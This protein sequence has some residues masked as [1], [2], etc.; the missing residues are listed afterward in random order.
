MQAFA[1]LTLGELIS[2]EFLNNQEQFERGLACL[3]K[4]VT[5]YSKNAQVFT[6]GEYSRVNL[7]L[8]TFYRLKGDFSQAKRHLELAKDKITDKTDRSWL[9]LV[10]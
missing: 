3:Q 10:H 5:L 4:A 2:K 9:N 7:S 6:P 1:N 8:A